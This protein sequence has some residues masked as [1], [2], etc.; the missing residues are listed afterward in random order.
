MPKFKVTK[1]SKRETDFILYGNSL[2]GQIKKGM[3]IYVP[4]NNFLQLTG[5]I[6]E[7]KHDNQQVVIAV[8]CSD[9]KE[10][11]FWETLNL[12]DEVLLIK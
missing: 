1:T 7:I 4:L 8:E 3:E 6:T 10:A 2:E 11:D 5:V 12:K 9:I